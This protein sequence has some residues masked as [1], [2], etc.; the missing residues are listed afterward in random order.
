M[1]QHHVR[2]RTLTLQASLEELVRLEDEFL[3]VG[4]EEKWRARDLLAY[5]RGNAPTCSICRWRW[6][7]QTP[8]E[9]ASW[10]RWTWLGN[11]LRYPVVFYHADFFQAYPSTQ[12]SVAISRNITPSAC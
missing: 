1:A 2:Y 12:L 11:H 7:P 5:S 8:R 3:L 6:C 9:R 10:W 4:A